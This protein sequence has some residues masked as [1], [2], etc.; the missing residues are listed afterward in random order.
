MSSTEVNINHVLTGVGEWRLL[1]GDLNG[2]WVIFCGDAAA[3]AGEA[4]DLR[5]DLR[6]DFPGLAEF[7]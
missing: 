6:G 4:A 1:R 2:D 7:C 3:F 5:G